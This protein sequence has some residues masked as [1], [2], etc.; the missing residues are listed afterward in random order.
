MRRTVI[1]VKQIS[2][3]WL[4]TIEGDDMQVN[5]DERYFKTFLDV[6]AYLHERNFK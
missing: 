6:L 5:V 1:E 4:L 3:G 2:N